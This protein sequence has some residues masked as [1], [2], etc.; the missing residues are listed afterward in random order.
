[1]FGPPVHVPCSEDRNADLTWAMGRI[2]AE[3]ERA[4]RRAPNQWFVFRELWP[5]HESVSR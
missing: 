4:V 1:V 5:E 2:A 3:I